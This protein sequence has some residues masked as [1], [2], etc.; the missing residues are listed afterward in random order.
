MSIRTRLER[1]EQALVSTEPAAPQYDLFEQIEML[2]A[3]ILGYLTGVTR[4]EEI[5]IEHREYVQEKATKLAKD[6]SLP[7]P[8]LKRLRDAGSDGD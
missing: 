6:F 5:P 7:E 1:L 3:M 8:P 4:L 2:Q